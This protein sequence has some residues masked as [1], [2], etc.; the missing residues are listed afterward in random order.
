MERDG[1]GMTEKTSK[2]G[3]VKG[4]GNSVFGAFIPGGTE[5]LVL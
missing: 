1:F 5:N 2:A 3:S 4:V